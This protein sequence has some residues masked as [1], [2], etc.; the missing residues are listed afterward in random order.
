MDS[1][2]PW[3]LWLVTLEMWAPGSDTVWPGAGYHAL[4]TVPGTDPDDVAERAIWFETA[5]QLGTVSA[6]GEGHKVLGVR[7][8]RRV[9][10]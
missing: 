9:I 1:L 8:V 4:R 10:R 3:G 2:K 6:G 5:R 7:K